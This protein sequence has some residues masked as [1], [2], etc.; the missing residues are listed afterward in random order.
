MI[1]EVG[2]RIDAFYFCPEAADSDHPDRKPNPGMLRRAMA[3]L[4][5]D[6]ARSF[7]VGDRDADL[8]AAQAAGVAGHLYAGG[9]L[10]PVVEAALAALDRP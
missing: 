5:L 2:A 3:D 10:L 7:M 1:C 4:A 9:S 6:P 8:L